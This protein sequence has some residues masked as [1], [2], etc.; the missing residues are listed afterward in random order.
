MRDG[1]IVLDGRAIEGRF[2]HPSRRLEVDHVMA[3]L[4]ARGCAAADLAMPPDACLEGGDVAV[5][6]HELLA[7]G[8]SA[9]TSWPTPRW[10][11]AWA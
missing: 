4:E 9:P 1:A 10:P 11:T 5:L 8:G 3:W 7:A 6:G 2:R